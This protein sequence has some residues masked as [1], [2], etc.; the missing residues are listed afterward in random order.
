MTR[1][2]KD[3]LIGAMSKESLHEP[4]GR[5]TIWMNP[6][7]RA[8]GFGRWVYC[9]YC[10]GKQRPVLGGQNQITCGKCGA[11]LSR[12]F[13]N[14]DCLKRWWPIW[15]KVM[16][17]SVYDESKGKFVHPMDAALRAIE[18]EDEHSP[19]AMAWYKSHHLPKK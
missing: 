5:V 12:D 4:G 14:L 7:R 1:A 17:E 8:K 10:Y 16:E 18:D 2:K 11:G 19:E 6:I 15:L 13:F 9:K 3:G